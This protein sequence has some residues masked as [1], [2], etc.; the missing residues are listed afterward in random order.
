MT[1]KVKSFNISTRYGFITDG[2]E[3][4][5]F[6]MRD[7]KSIDPPYKGLTVEFTPYYSEKGWRAEDIREEK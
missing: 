2:H 6:H 5:R 7:W 1:G 3:D 4:F